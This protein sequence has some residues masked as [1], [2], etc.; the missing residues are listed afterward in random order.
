MN[1]QNPQTKTKTQQQQNPIK[2]QKGMVK[3][4]AK[5]ELGCLDIPKLVDI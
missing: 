3:K 1:K 5:I 2:T 4:I